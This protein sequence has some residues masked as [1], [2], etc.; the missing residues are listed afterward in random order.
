MRTTGY[1]WVHQHSFWIIAEYNAEIKVWHLFRSN[2][3]LTD[4]D[5]KEINERKIDEALKIIKAKR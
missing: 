2:T 1:Y 5:F 4:S 3:A